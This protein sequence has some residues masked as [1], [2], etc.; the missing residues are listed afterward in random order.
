MHPLDLEIPAPVV[1][2]G[3]YVMPAFATL[4]VA[5][6]A[7]ARRWYAAMG[8]TELAV[9]PGPAD[10]PSL[11]H[12]RRYRYQ[13]LLLV[14]ATAGAATG[15]GAARLS[16][17]H[18]GPLTDLDGIAEALRATNLGEVEGPTQTPWYAIEVV[19]R[20]ADGNTVVLTGRAETP[21]PSAWVDEVRAS[22][23]DSE[24]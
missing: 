3:I 17:A 4:P 2:R 9:M 12:L 20:D 21:P 6:L 13:D 7:K 8:F 24:S 15:T 10:A 16:F 11:V 14:P 19:G 5:D 22:I 18:T 1:D 23:T